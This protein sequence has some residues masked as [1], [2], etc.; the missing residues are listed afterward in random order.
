[1]FPKEDPTFSTIVL[2]ENLRRMRKFWSITTYH[3][4]FLHFKPSALAKQK[5]SSHSFS[6]LIRCLEAGGV[7]QWRESMAKA[8]TGNILQ[9]VAV[10]FKY[11]PLFPFSSSSLRLLIRLWR[12]SL[13]CWESIP[14]RVSSSLVGV[15][16]WHSIR[17]RVR[18]F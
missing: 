9:S 15:K 10:T 3:F 11:I 18:L 8:Q 6:S 14:V 12:S 2:T 13:Q 1:M 17:L 16:W 7:S 5:L 4:Y